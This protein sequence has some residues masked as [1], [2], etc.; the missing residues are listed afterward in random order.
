MSSG[1]FSYIL[2][3]KPM[4]L[5][6]SVYFFVVKFFLCDSKPLDIDVAG[7]WEAQITGDGSVVDK[8]YTD[9][10]TI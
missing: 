7:N 4:V 8:L 9:G 6:D 10:Y 2:Q 3:L 5:F 1:M